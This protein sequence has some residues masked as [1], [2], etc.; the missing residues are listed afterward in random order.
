M[1]REDIKEQI[2]KVEE[3]KAIYS[4]KI[5]EI[6]KRTAEIGFSEAVIALKTEADNEI[7]VC[8]KVLRD[9]ARILTQF[10]R[11]PP[12]TAL[13]CAATPG[14]V[15][16]A[17]LPD[18]G[19]VPAS[20]RV[21]YSAIKFSVS[22]IGTEAEGE[23]FLSELRN[24]ALE[25]SGM[26]PAKGQEVFAITPSSVKYIKAEFLEWTQFPEARVTVAGHTV[27]APFVVMATDAMA[28]WVAKGK[29]TV[30]ADGVAQ[31]KA[32]KRK[33]EK[34]KAPHGAM[35][36]VVAVLQ[37][38]HKSALDSLKAS[39]KAE[40]QTTAATNAKQVAAVKRASMIPVE[41]TEVRFALNRLRDSTG[42]W[43]ELVGEEDGV[44][45]LVECKAPRWSVD[46]IPVDID[47]FH[48]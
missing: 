1:Q 30:S 27:L 10:D 5:E 39:G 2:S 3:L 44:A 20:I 22:F 26:D 37:G 21:R 38:G 31:A 28:Q 16:L 29:V 7:A 32:A 11:V 8:T 46:I 17:R 43:F 4:S 24:P 12:S 9:M 18:V 15:I 34:T 14:T 23:V 13:P 48:P 6:S 45:E 41:A 35:E 19:M 42:Q 33:A 47:P 36:E 40:R 25:N